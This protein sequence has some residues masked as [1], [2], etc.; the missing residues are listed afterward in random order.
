MKTIDF[1]YFIERYNAG[2][3]SIE[4][5]EWFRKEIE[6]NDKLRI[7]V[8]IRKQTDGV[9]RNQDIISLRNKLS[10]IERARESQSPVKKT[11]KP[12]F[13]TVAAVVTVL[14]LSG[15]ITMLSDKNLSN[16]EIIE[17]YYRAYEPPAAQRSVK[18]ETNEVFSL[19]L[20]YYNTHDYKNAAHYFSKVLEMDPQNMHSSFLK[21]VANFEEK[22]YPEA[23]QSFANVINDNNNLFIENAKWYLALCYIKTDERDKA[24]RQLEIIRTEGGLYKDEARKIIRKLK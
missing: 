12:V 8:N 20:D 11:K 17:R 13:M 18:T 5:R 16:E 4:E 19:A 6:G 7:E 2:E 9:L 23:K 21:G 15:G 3:M 1:S 14:I 22:K 10:I 24:L